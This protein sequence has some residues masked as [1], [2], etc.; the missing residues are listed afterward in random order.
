MVYKKIHLIVSDFSIKQSARIFESILNN[1]DNKQICYPN[2]GHYT[3]YQSIRIKMDFKCKDSEEKALDIIKRLKD[4]TEIIDFNPQQWQ[5]K[6]Q[7]SL[8]VR[9][10]CHLASNCT[11]LLIKLEEFKNITESN[12]LHDAFSL[13]FF[14]KLFDELKLPIPFNQNRIN[15]ILETQNLWSLMNNSVNAV[16]KVC[17]SNK[18]L[19]YE[20]LFNERF[21]HMLCNNL[22]ILPNTEDSVFWRRFCRIYNLPVSK[23]NKLDAFRLFCDSYK[24]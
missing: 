5:N 4:N 6:T 10:A 9:N 8:V 16:I 15:T 17:K 23:K 18:N 24:K 22:L 1:I 13:I 7:K 12:R 14:N 19:F 20:P 3:E 11:L 2:F 21:I